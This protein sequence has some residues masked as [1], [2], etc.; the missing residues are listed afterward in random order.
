VCLQLHIC[1][2][3][4]YEG[5]PLCSDV[6]HTHVVGKTPESHF[7]S[8]YGTASASTVRLVRPSE[9]KTIQDTLQDINALTNV[10]LQQFYVQTKWKINIFCGQA[11]PV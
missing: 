4:N 7:R 1:K 3:P 9:H 11:V 6:R 8:V 10:L 2:H 5:G